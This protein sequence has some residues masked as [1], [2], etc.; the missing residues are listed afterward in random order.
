MLD[1]SLFPSS[2]RFSF[3]KTENKTANLDNFHRLHPL[4]KA[5]VAHS[6]DIRKA[7]FGDARWCAHQALSQ[8]GRDKGEPILRG[9]RGMPLWPSS[10]SGSLTHTDGFRAAVVA[11]RLLVRSMGLDAEPAEP[12]PKDVLGSIARVGE[13]P[14][15][16]RLADNGIDCADRLLFCAKE[17]TYKAWFPLTH[18]WLGFEQAEIDIRDDGTFVSYL[19]V[20]PTPVP[21]ISGKWVLRDGY[22]IATTA[23]T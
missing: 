20:R 1:E 10:V 19:L 14:Q 6:V 9:E 13:L 18:R 12:L 2:A 3:I 7:E 8:L 5:L 23:V 4:E 15:L 17:A 22:V 16:K 11:P 21:F